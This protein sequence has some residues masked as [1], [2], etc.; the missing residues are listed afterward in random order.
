MLPRTPWLLL[1][2]FL[3]LFWAVW[4]SL[5]VASNVADGLKAA[6]VLPESFRF[7]SGNYGMILEVTAPFGL[8]PAVAGFLF[9]GV[10]LWESLSLVLFWYTGLTFQGTKEP[11]RHGRL[12]LTFTVSLALWA[13]FQIACEAFPSELAYKIEGVH[14]MVF[15]AQLATL[16]AL[17]LLPDD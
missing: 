4:L 6:G 8:P 16:L 13:A 15:A 11:D 17:V 3:L 5:V 7:V 10:I 1:K 9:V 2:R 12:V 14:R